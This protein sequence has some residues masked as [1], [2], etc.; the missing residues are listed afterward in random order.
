VTAPE[1]PDRPAEDVG[2]PDPMVVRLASGERI[3][4]L[5]WPGPP[6]VRPLLLI[7]GLSRTSWTWLPVARQLAGRYPLAA[8]DL[9]GHGASDAPREGY[10]LESLALD[11]LT[12]AAAQGW[13]S[14]VG[15][16][17]VVVA[18][19]GLGAL[20]AVE[21]ARLEPDS[22]AGLVLVDG[23]WEE[24]GETSRL[25]PPELLAAMTDPPEILAS[26]DAYLADRRAFDPQTWDADQ[27]RAARA[28]VVERHAGHVSPV[29]RA[30]VLRRLVETL[31]AYQPLDALGRV[32]QPVAVLVAGAGTADDEERRERLLALDDVERARAAAGLVPADVR[33]IDGVGHELM[34]HRPGAVA[35]AIEDVAHASTA[36][37]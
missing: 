11:M 4:Y 19:H 35:A 31:Y 1:R 2:E 9:R 25:S 15:G 20:V 18:G 27:E 26:M 24:V 13:G 22:V 36:S 5:A 16:P 10:D 17:A 6:G 34:R 32:P 30:S 3:A 12:V 21:T 7:H 29:V 28:A 33:L 14:P 37:T 23:G 8:P